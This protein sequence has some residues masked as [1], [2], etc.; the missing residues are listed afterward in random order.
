MRISTNQFSMDFKESM[1]QTEE[2]TTGEFFAGGG[3]VTSGMAE[4]PGIKPLWILNHDPVAL[5]TN[6]YHHKGVK[7]YWADLYVQDEHEMEY[8][9][10]VHAS[11]ECDW[12]SKANAGKKKNI[13]S[14]TMGWELYRYLKYLLPLAISIENVPEYKKWAPLDENGEPDVE[15]VGEE[16]ERWKQAIID[17]GYEYKETIRNAADDGMPTRRVRF[18]C[19]FTRPGI[20]IEFPEQSHSEKGTGGKEKWPSCREHIEVNNHGESVFGRQFNNNLPKHRRKPLCPNSLKR[21]AGGIKKQYPDFYQFLCK[22]HGGNNP[23][24]SYSINSPIMTIDGSNR[25]QF[26]TVENGQFIQDHCR[27][28]NY[29]D[30]DDPLRTQLTWQTKQLIS[31]ESKQLQIALEKLQFIMDHCHS[32]KFQ[33]TTSPLGAQTTRQ[34]KQLTTIE[35]DGSFIVQNYGKSMGQSNN[36]DEAIYTIPCRDVHQLIRVEKMQFIVKYFNSNGNPGANNESLEGPL[37][38]VLTEPHHQL[39]TILD[40]FD[41]KARFLNRE[42]LAAC[43]TFPRDYFSHKELKLSGKKAIQMIGNAV[44]PKWAK[45]LFKPTIENLIE[46]KKRMAVA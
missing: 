29:Q 43:S 44:P 18:F 28:D 32:D 11:V 25:H 21:I 10:H 9:D 2:A 37:S 26:V 36:L 16:F 4:I 19:F 40:N 27:V 12:H 24:R 15:R 34:T 13:G 45:K 31:L 7:V 17:L 39:I 5:K 20:E 46:Y 23:E 38:T 33:D 3:G 8:V 22:Y 42:E 14:Y 1:L 41:I 35:I 6:A 30:L